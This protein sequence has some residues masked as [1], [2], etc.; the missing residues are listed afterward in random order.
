MSLYA[1]LHQV[2]A[3]QKEMKSRQEKKNERFKQMSFFLHSCMVLSALQSSL[4]A[5][6]GPLP[7]EYSLFPN[8]RHLM[9]QRSGSVD[10]AFAVTTNQK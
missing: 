1:G 8:T 6:V 3:N 5:R 10:L 2:T 7:V 4:Q 9:K